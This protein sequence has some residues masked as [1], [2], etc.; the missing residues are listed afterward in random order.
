MNREDVRRY[1]VANGLCTA[2]T[3][4]QFEKMLTMV[5]I[6][7][8]IANIATV[9]WIMSEPIKHADEIE[10]ELLAL[11]RKPYEPPVIEIVSGED[12]FSSEEY[13]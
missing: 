8:P 10:K 11:D 6:K 13:E 1:C 7:Q 9:I 5:D 4:E 2:G 12:M 3:T